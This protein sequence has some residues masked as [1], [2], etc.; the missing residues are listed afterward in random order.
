M[1][2]SLLLHRGVLRDLLK[3]RFTKLRLVSDAIV[4]AAIARPTRKKLVIATIFAKFEAK[5][6]ICRDHSLFRAGNDWFKTSE[7]QKT[8]GHF[9]ASSQKARRFSRYVIKLLHPRHK[10]EVSD[11]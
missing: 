8:C 9:S 10:S 7:P 11:A 1:V 4:I 5:T 2:G 6:R 3:K